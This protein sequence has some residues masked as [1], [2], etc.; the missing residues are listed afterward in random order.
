MDWYG[1]ILVDNVISC[2]WNQGDS[3][4]AE[5]MHMAAL[6]TNYYHTVPKNKKTKTTTL[7]EA[8]LLSSEFETE[9]AQLFEAFKQ[10]V[11]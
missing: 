1:L 9:V 5:G 6:T 7:E 4:A 10:T 2:A 3:T 11:N 8:A